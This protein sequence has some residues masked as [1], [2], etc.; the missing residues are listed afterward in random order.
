MMRAMLLALCACAPPSAF[1]FVASA[2]PFSARGSARGVTQSKRSPDVV[3]ALNFD[4]DR[5]R[6]VFYTNHSLT[7]QQM[8]DLKTIDNTIDEL[9]E[10]V[11]ENRLS[12]GVTQEEVPRTAL[13]MEW[14]LNSEL[15]LVLIAVRVPSLSGDPTLQVVR[16]GVQRVAQ[17]L[18]RHAA[19][20]LPK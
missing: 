15:L 4:P 17:D 5:M 14:L 8:R 7:P 11:F 19:Q 3:C 20:R 1:A 9:Y 12:P 6:D 2:R 18:G 10:I 13:P 16:H